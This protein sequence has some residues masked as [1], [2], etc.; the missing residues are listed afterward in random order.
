MIRKKYRL[1]IFLFVPALAMLACNLLSGEKEEATQVVPQPEESAPGEVV[2]A[3]LEVI[4]A[5]EPE[6][7]PGDPS[8]PAEPPPPS[9]NLGDEYRSAEG[10][11]SFRPIPDWKLEEIIG[12]VT[13]EAPNADPEFGPFIMMMGGSGDEEKSTEDIYQEFNS[14]MDKSIEIVAERDIMVGGVQAKRI[15]IAGTPSGEPVS[16]SVV[17]AAV[18]PTQQFTIMGF[19]RRDEWQKIAPI[20]DSVLASVTFFEPEETA[21]DLSDIDLGGEGE[22]IIPGAPPVSDITSSAD[23]PAGGFAYLISTDDG[24]YI[25]VEEGTIQDQ[26][27]TSEY[28]IGL[29]SQDQNQTLSLFLPLDLGADFLTL[30][31]YDSGSASKAPSAAIY[32]GLVFYTATDGFLWI[33]SITDNTITGEFY[34]TGTNENGITAYVTGFFNQIPIGQ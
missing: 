12:I 4:Q 29:V 28:V 27:T 9:A 5:E 32:I 23:L 17:F 10:G 2:Q 7:Q 31:P 34:F 3:T 15:E 33:E 24:Q 8:A 11:F 18:S 30:K 19:A 21:P 25:N 1:L 20:F 22:E 13:M 16:G 6:E 26:S 14:E